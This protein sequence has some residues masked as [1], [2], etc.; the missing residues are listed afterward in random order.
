MPGQ[1]LGD[2][3]FL[4]QSFERTQTTSIRW[5]RKDSA[6]L[7]QSTIFLHYLL[8]IVKQL[9]VGFCSRLLSM[10]YYPL[11]I[12]KERFDVLFLQVIKIYE[13][14]TS[15]TTEQ[16]QI[17]YHA[18][19]LSGDWYFHEQANLFFCQELPYRLFFLVLISSERVLWIL[20][21]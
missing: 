6:I 7:A 12:V 20:K 5:Y 3:A 17:T 2:A 14:E 15:E 19:L 21:I 8:G 11:A 9:D 18:H 1:R 10:D 4:A 16:K 13:G